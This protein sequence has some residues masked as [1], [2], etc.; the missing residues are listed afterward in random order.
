[1]EELR[2]EL[3]EIRKAAEGAGTDSQKLINELYRMSPPIPK[4]NG[5]MKPKPDVL[6]LGS[7]QKAI[8]KM[9]FFYHPDKIDKS[10]LKYKILCEEITKILTEHS[11][12]ISKM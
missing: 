5:T 6:K 11:E 7:K 9:I 12:K 8:K 4:K 10:N 1:M 3:E 2:P